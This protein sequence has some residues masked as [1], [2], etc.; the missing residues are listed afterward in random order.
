MQRSWDLAGAHE[1]MRDVYGP[2]DSL[3]RALGRSLAR[4][5]DRLMRSPWDRFKPPQLDLLATEKRAPTGEAPSKAPVA[6]TAAPPQEVPSVPVAE[7]SRPP[8]GEPLLVPLSVLC[9]DP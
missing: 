5:H 1:R 3:A 4:A 8:T 7:P 6:E 9:E 2:K